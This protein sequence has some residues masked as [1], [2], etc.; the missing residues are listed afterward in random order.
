M[1][2][3]VAQ[4]Y[5]QAKSNN[6]AL[7][8]NYATLN[9]LYPLIP[10]NTSNFLLDYS[11]QHTRFDRLFNQKHGEK[12][13]CIVASDIEEA[14]TEFF[15]LCNDVCAVHLN[16]WARM[17]YALSL[18]Y[19]PLWNVDGT[20]TT[21]YTDHETVIDSAQ[22]KNTDKEFTVPFQSNAEE[23]E[24]SKSEMVIDAYVDKNTSKAHS[25]T[26]TRT[27]NIGTTKSTD[28]LMAEYEMREKNFWGLVF[29]TIEKEVGLFY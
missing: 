25:V 22:K 26:L 13:A 19:N 18:Y 12:F 4:I 17:Y 8:F 5:Q 3:T 2:W 14:Y 21:S 24:A 11:T 15:N 10:D 28:L 16:D 20:E 27:G 6:A 7:L 1:M 9:P 29:R 23:K